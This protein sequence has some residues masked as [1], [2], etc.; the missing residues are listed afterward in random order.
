ML[1]NTQIEE[2]C[3]K[4]DI[5]LEKCCYKSNLKEMK[6]KYN[7]SYIVNLENELNKDGKRNNN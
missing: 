3:G 1:T 2:L 7:R 4:M 6:L 5:P